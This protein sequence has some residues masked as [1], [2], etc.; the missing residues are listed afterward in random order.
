MIEKNYYS[1]FKQSL[2]QPLLKYS[3]SLEES[4][5]YNKFEQSSGQSL[6]KYFSTLDLE[7]WID[8][9]DDYYRHE[10]TFLLRILDTPKG[11]DIYS[12]GLIWVNNVDSATRELITRGNDILLSKYIV[13]NDSDLLE[14]TFKAIR[15][16]KLNVNQDLLAQIISSKEGKPKLRELAAITLI[17]VHENSAT[18]FWDNLDLESDQFLIPSYIAFHRKNNP[19]KGLGKLKLLQQKPENISVFETPILYS[20]LQISTSTSSVE[21]YKVMQRK[22]P[23]WANTFI[24]ELFDDYPELD[25][26]KNKVKKPYEDILEKM[27]IEYSVLEDKTLPKELMNSLS[28]LIE[29]VTKNPAI[30]GVVNQ[31]RYNIIS[32]DYI[33]DMKIIIDELFVAVYSS[34]NGKY[35]EPPKEPVYDIPENS[36]YYD[37][38]T[39]FLYP[40]F[41]DQDRIE[42]AGVIPY[43]TQTSIAIVLHKDNCLYK[44]WQAL[45][46]TAIKDNSLENNQEREVDI[47]I[48]KAD[49]KKWLKELVENIYNTN[50]QIHSIRGYVFHSIIKQFVIEN[51][52]NDD[53][54]GEVLKAPTDLSIVKEKLVFF[55]QPKVGEQIDRNSIL[56]LDPSDAF[57]ETENG[58]VFMSFLQS[59]FFKVVTVRHGLDIPIGIG[60]SLFALPRLLNNGTWKKL[61]VLMK[62]K[63][64]SHKENLSKVGIELIET[65]AISELN[66]IKV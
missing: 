32:P 24:K 63:L 35:H 29:K 27:G 45:R 21:E 28:L 62:D 23:T 17:A 4:N 7:D 12:Y 33:D 60:Y 2:D 26:F 64:S 9:F 5:Y 25:D 20:L 8:F 47:R 66:T 56:L 38:P 15:Y 36:I 39:I 37:K 42:K 55:K 53:T 40:Y 16:L 58:Q 3:G 19:V 44:K 34:V 51:V 31:K 1:K 65:E 22:F 13:Q 41:L 57:K 49:S 61:Q 11:E 54:L 59:T 6:L 43:A 50:G 14:E 10:L 46:D 52:E 48:S 18:T 30:L